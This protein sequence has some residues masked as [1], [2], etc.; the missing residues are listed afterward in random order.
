MKRLFWRFAPE[1]VL[2][3]LLVSAGCDPSNNVPAGPPQLVSF[4]VVSNAS[5]QPVDTM[6]DGGLVPISGFVHLT[7]TF[8]RLLNPVPV[9][10]Y[11]GGMD[12]GAGDDAIT[13]TPA[14]PAGAVIAYTSIY[15]PNGGPVELAPGV[16]GG[17]I[18]GP[19]PT[20]ITMASPSFPSASMITAKLDPTRIKSKKGEPFTG[21]GMLMFQTA[22]FSAD[23]TVPMGDPD[24]DAGADAG[25]PPVSPMM[26][27][28]TIAFNN[29]VGA[30]IA[31]HVS[32][33]AGNA[34]FADVD[35]A[36]DSGNPTQVNVTPKT[37]WPPNATITVTVDDTA[38]DAFGST[39]GTPTSASFPTGD[40]AP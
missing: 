23:I 7:A 35:I 37:T 16:S 9:T 30:D 18:F 1:V 24:P 27:A 8:D 5:G 13:L 12:F 28:V 22:P 25:P 31:A 34:V 2:G 11:D 6:G 39:T 29:V 26:Q 4:V 19:G 20:I 21:D 32:V 15:S 17:L 33:T 14:L 10:G 36:A 38:D 40:K 3:S